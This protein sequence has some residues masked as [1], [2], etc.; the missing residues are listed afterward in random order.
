[1]RFIFE[2]S[3]INAD[4]LTAFFTNHELNAEISAA[5]ET[6]KAV[7]IHA[8]DQTAVRVRN[9]VQRNGFRNT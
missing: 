1:M 8:I 5:A 4:D 9:I 7:S 2:A 6:G 3:A